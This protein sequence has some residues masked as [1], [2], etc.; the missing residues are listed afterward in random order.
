MVEVRKITSAA[1]KEEKPMIQRTFRPAASSESTLAVLTTTCPGCDRPSSI[2]YYN[3]RT[4]T[5]L[6]GIVHFRLQIRRCHHRPCPLYRRPF[7][8]EVEGRLAL[9]RHE[10]GLD[11]LALIGAL[12]YSEHR[13]VPEIHRALEQRGVV[14]AQRSVTNLLDRYDELRALSVADLDRLA[15]LLRQQG[16]VILAVDALQPDV[17]HEVLW[18]I[19]DCISSEVLLA[20]SLLSSTQDDLAKLLGEVKTRLDELQVPVAGVVSDG[21]HSIRNG[22][23]KAL[24]GVPHQLCQ[25]HFL[26]EAALPIYERDRHA[27]KELKK[28]V[29]GI[30]AIERKV[31]HREDA[32]AK[33]VQ[34]YCAAVRSA[35][36]DD[37][38]PPLAA[39]G[40]KLH[41]RL[42]A[43]AT[44]IDQLPEQESL[45]KELIRLR[46]LLG[47]GLEQTQA[48][49]P[50]VVEGFKWVHE[51]A[52][53]L[54]NKGKQPGKEVKR[55]VAKVIG[56]MGAKAE[57]CQEQAQEPL[58]RALQHFVKVYQSY[59]PGLFHCY[60]V[61]DLPRTNNDLEQLFGS[62]RYH[63]RR[64][65]G[66]KVASPGLV[67]RGS[68]RLVAGVATR[69]RLV[70]G[71]ELAPKK[72]ADWQSQ[73]AEL[74]RRRHSRVLQRRFRRDPKGYLGNL[75][76]QYRQSRLPT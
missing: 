76:Q 39:S 12:R 20:R 34:G 8:P 37:G 5:T 51:V 11:I 75:E 4:L 10:F 56:R 16:R 19:R 46:R 22:V 41:E 48:L 47:K 74:D 23:A 50:E 72:L 63:E 66:R 70:S 60:D 7:R 53:V 54:E 52:E 59:E 68:V 55:Q 71:E 26:R 40:L 2:D 65:S 49:W 64:A 32:V 44:S 13:S 9:P 1:A 27:K 25:F 42:G 24:P 28:R 21:Q 35:L 61:M 14:V 33:V 31:E 29:R 18:V 30:R 17:G 43:I 45:P 57:R 38:R 15:P 6:T 58:A 67:V 36:T 69:L 3:Q 62:H 73:R